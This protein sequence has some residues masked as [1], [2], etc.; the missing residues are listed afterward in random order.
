MTK[1]CVS[2]PKRRIDFL[3]SEFDHGRLSSE[4]YAAGRVVQETLERAFL[5]AG[6]AWQGK[7]DISVSTDAAAVHALDVARQVARTMERVERVVGKMDAR[8]LRGLLGDRLSIDELATR[9]GRAGPRGCTY[10]L[11]RTRDALEQL[12]EADQ[13]KGPAR[14]A[15]HPT[16]RSREHVPHGGI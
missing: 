1:A 7:V 8:L 15:A 14:G 4:A 16:P 12:A 6:F 10:L 5:L 2:H 11:S 13:A 3:R 9:E